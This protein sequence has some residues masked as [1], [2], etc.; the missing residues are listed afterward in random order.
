MSVLENTVN[1]L[2]TPSATNSTELNAVQVDA[3]GYIFF[4]YSGHIKSAGNNPDAIRRIITDR[5]QDHTPDPQVQV[6]R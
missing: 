1:G 6:L 2:L 3:D 5:P 4:P